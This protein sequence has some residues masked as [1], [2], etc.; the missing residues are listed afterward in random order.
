MKHVNQTS[1]IKGDIR[2]VGK[3]QSIESCI[4]RS[5]KLKKRIKIKC[6]NCNENIE[7]IPYKEKHQ[8][9]HFCNKD[10]YVKWARKGG[11]KLRNFI[12]TEKGKQTLQK[13]W[14]NNGKK[15]WFRKS[16][17]EKIQWN[18]KMRSSQ[19]LRPNKP[20]SILKNIF[21]QH[22]LQYKY[23]GAG[24]FWIDKINPDFVNCNGKKIII[25]VFGNYWH[26]LDKIKIKDQKKLKI[27]K[28]YGWNRVVLWEKEIYNLP[29]KK[30]L[31]RIKKMEVSYSSI[32]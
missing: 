11:W 14:S 29:A 4:K 5:L 26:N 32:K 28:K 18:R 2:L 9:H 31:N 23:T 12:L 22:K 30:I 20:E 21:K 17:K 3:K 7:I 27:L 1:F 19:F 6:N 24:D 15:T 8:K 10:C 25:E 13:V 16:K